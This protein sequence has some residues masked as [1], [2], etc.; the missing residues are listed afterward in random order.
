MNDVLDWIPEQ[1][2]DGS[3]CENPKSVLK[4]LKGKSAWKVEKN[5]AMVNKSGSGFGVNFSSKW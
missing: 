4:V 5:D 1:S 3:L 2:N